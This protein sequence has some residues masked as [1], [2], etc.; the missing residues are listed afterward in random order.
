MIKE[1]DHLEFENLRDLFAH[2][3][4]ILSMVA[5]LFIFGMVFVSD[6]D[7]EIYALSD[8]ADNLSAQVYSAYSE[9]QKNYLSQQ[10]RLLRPP[11]IY[12][13]PMVSF[14][15]SNDQFYEILDQLENLFWLR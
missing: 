5:S 13:R 3:L 4:V 2:G 11:L 8:R 12:D 10:A 6:H 9:H 15:H 7:R 14:Q 1:Y